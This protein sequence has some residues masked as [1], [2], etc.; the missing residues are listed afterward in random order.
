VGLFCGSLL[1]QCRSVLIVSFLQVSFGHVFDTAGRPLH[2]NASLWSR[3]LRCGTI[4]LQHTA[5]ALQ[6]AETNCSTTASHCST[7]NQDVVGAEH[8]TA[9]HCNR[10][11]QTATDCNRL[12]HTAAYCNTLQHTATHCNTLEPGCRRR[13]LQH[14]ANT[15]C[16]A[17]HHTAT[18]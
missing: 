4:R 13:G 17:L 5:T 18:H 10:L 1:N 14:I 16:N 6:H 9:I 3:E 2:H 11:Q 8:L 15:H 7:L 12:Q